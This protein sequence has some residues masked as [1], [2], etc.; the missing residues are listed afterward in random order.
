MNR[1]W[2]G[3]LLHAKYIEEVAPV[4]MTPIA[5]QVE[6]EEVARLFG[7]KS[8]EAN[9]IIFGERVDVVI[10]HDVFDAPKV[11]QSVQDEVLDLA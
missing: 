10:P 2:Y 1:L 5:F 8:V 4:S 3:R 9:K 11:V 6:H 7:C